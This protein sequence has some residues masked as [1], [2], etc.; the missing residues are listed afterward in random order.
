MPS[1]TRAQGYP[2]FKQHGFIKDVYSPLIDKNLYART[3]LP[4]TTSSKYIGQIKRK[5]DKVI[6]TRQPKITTEPY[7]AGK[8]YDIT[9]NLEDPI[10][11]YVNR[12]RRWKQYYDE[13]DANRTHVVGLNAAT[14]DAAAEAI[15]RDVEVE[16]FGEFPSFVPK[17]NTGNSAGCTSGSYQ[18]GSLDHPILLD[19]QNVLDYVMQ[20]LHVL[21]ETNVTNESG[22]VSILVPDIVA[23]Y[24]RCAQGVRDAHRIGGKSSL[25]TRYLQP[26]DGLGD[27]YVSNLLPKLDNGAFPIICNV[28]EAMNA[29]IAA[30]KTCVKDDLDLYD[31]TLLRGYAIYDWGVAREE[32]LAIG[33]IKP[34][35]SPL[36][37]LE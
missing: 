27:V 20:F 36:V 3:Y 32:G 17:C 26:L 25:K 22:V 4:R 30:R 13:N 9:T 11:M 2:S 14:I 7:V 15:A 34:N 28:K 18:L 1:I 37:A 8:P 19:P 35:K 10:E 21:N 24:I 23:Y 33:Y 31:G 16:Y 5:G 12:G 6:I 29:V